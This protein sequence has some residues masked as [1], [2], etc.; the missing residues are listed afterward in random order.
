MTSFCRAETDGEYA[1]A[2]ALLSRQ[3][4]Q[5]ISLDAFTQA[6]HDASLISCSTTHGIP[7][8]LGGT[9]ASLDVTYQV[10]GSVIA[11]DGTMSFVRESGG[12]RVNSMSPDLF[13]LSS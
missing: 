4:Q 5:R 3:A 7:I 9:Q 6:S 11:V 1:T 8:I 2:Y 10:F 13:H 12:W